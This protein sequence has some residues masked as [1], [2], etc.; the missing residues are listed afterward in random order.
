M[1]HYMAHP[2]LLEHKA[3]F[4]VCAFSLLCAFE[5]EVDLRTPEQKILYSLILRKTEPVLIACR[6]A[7]LFPLDWDQDL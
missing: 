5:E 3:P 4:W 1:A 6:S 7:G 2:L